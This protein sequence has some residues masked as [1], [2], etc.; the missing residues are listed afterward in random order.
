[1]IQ[2][3]KTKQD[4][5]NEMDT[6]IQEYLK[7]GG[8]I[9]QI[10]QGISGRDNNANLNHT[11]PFTPSEHPT[12]TLVNDSVKAIDDRKQ[13]KKLPT[14]TAKHRPKKRII[15]DDFGEPVREVWE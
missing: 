3:L 13:K 7:T 5:R 4:A 15:Y 1:M 10:D 8:E 12:R 9:N 14:T 6:E 11:I 2:K